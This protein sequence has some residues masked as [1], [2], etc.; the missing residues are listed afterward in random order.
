MTGYYASSIWVGHDNYKALSSKTT[1]SSAA[2]PLWQ[3]YMKKIHS[4]LS[5]RDIL[6]G[7]P[8]AYGLS[9]VT[10]CAVSGQLATSACRNDAM[11]YGVVTDYWAAGTAPTVHC[12]MHQTTRIC[13]DSGMTASDYCYNVEERGV[14]TIPYGHP[15]HPFL[16]TQYEDVLAE[17]LG[18]SSVYG[19]Q[20]RCSWHTTYQ[21]S[22]TVENTLIPDALMLLAQAQNQLITMDV[23]SAAYSNLQSA[24]TNLQY[25]IGQ[26]NPSQAE[27]A[28]A[29]AMVTQAMSGY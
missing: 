7:D 13:V 28:T 27:V 15:L 18:A 1:G 8:S 21:E 5:K 23:Y 6:D 25:V 17:Y 9:K 22:A 14:V 19:S 24:I 10:T 11:D 3:A 20:G 29:M 4:G 12:Q 2:A 16:G 26:A